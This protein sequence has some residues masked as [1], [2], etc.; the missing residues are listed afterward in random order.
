MVKYVLIVREDVCSAN[1]KD[2]AAV[3]KLLEVAH[4]F[5]DIAKYEDCVAAEKAEMQAVIDNLKAQ[6]EALSAVKLTEPEKGIVNAFRDCKAASDREYIA[7]IEKKQAMLDKVNDK[8]AQFARQIKDCV[9]SN[10]NENK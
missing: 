2:E 3:T 6:I 7:E 10:E 8:F 1:G 9:A 5:G 4:K